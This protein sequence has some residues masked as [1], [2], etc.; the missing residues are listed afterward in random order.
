MAARSE[1][2]CY[3]ESR[4]HKIATLMAKD[5]DFAVFRTFSEL[6]FLNIL[7]L[8]HSLTASEEKLCE[9]LGKR[10]DVSEIIIEIRLLLKEY[11]EQLR[12]NPRYFVLRDS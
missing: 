2:L 11:S 12:Y 4:L 6:N 3:D 7:H 5:N 1:N 10:M 8:Q 9:A